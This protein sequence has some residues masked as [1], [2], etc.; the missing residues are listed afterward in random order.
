ME[1]GY[2]VRDLERVRIMNLT[3]DGIAEGQYRPIT[4]AEFTELRNYLEVDMDIKEEVK[5]IMEMKSN[6]T[7]IVTIIWMHRRLQTMSMI[8]S[9][10]V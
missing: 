6:I 9:C 10:S 5:N 2:H 7:A 4:A 8:C 1:C 3:L